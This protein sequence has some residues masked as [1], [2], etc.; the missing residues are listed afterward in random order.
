MAT[1][2]R[3]DTATAAL[4]EW[5]ADTPGSIIP[6]EVREAARWL[7]LDHLACAIGGSTLQPGQI[8]LGLFREQ[9]GTSQAS[10]HA[11]GKQTALLNAVYLN[12]ALS[13]LL[14]F[15][16]THAIA[17]PGGTAIPP[18]LG[19]AEYLD[20]SGAEVVDAVVFAYE[21][22]LR[23]QAAGMPSP[24][25]Y[26]HVYGL[27]TWQTLGAAVAAGRLLGL[28]VDQWRHAFG[29]AAVNAPVPNMRK[30]GL[31]PGERPFSWSKNNYGWAAQGGT[32]GAL[33]AQRGFVGQTAILDSDR[34]FWRMAG[35][36][37]WDP[38]S[39]TEGLGT[40]WRL[41]ETGL[42]PYAACRWTHTAVDAVGALRTQHPDLTPERV[43]HLQLETFYEVANNL[44]TLDPADIIDAQ[45]S[46]RHVIALE[47]AGRSARQ[48]L[49]EA[50]LADPLI[51]DLR[52]RITLVDAPDLSDRYFR[53]HEIP[54]RL[55]L[56]TVDG[57]VLTAEVDAPWG[58]P[59]HPFE[60]ADR[61]AKYRALTVP[62]IGE[63]ASEQFEAGVL[64]LD[65]IRS[66]RDILP[67]RRGRID[68]E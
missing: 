57:Q 22:M 63:A 9:G 65:E 2:S 15:D 34:G 43:R 67:A 16:D 55:T 48:G 11:T 3:V 58:D 7:I 61:L 41:P 23:V 64:N 49:R 24:E 62:V 8:L 54:A 52:R 5:L 39:L 37:R 14:D 38:S 56:T 33:L 12:A 50:D 36:D 31:E 19:V 51:A 30:L 27:S 53:R 42:K 25:R 68:G 21:I 18:A 28:S 60:A 66:L 4:A 1:G 47:L 29:L 45:F 32:L 46:V 20:R 26:R 59:R 6:A 35:S 17:H 10:V 13:N 44:N 40:D